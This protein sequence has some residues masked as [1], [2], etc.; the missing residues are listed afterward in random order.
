MNKTVFLDAK[1][2]GPGIDFSEL[3]S[4]GDFVK[5]ED[6]APEEVVERLQ[7]AQTVIVNKTRITAEVIAAC[8]NLKLICVAATGMNN[9]DLDSAAAAGIPVKNAVGYSTGSV[10]QQTFAML[11]A[12]TNRIAFFDNYVKSGQ[13]SQSQLFTCYD[14]VFSELAGKRAG[15]IGLGEI[16]RKSA[17]VLTAMGAEVVYFST[18][19]KNLDQ[20][21]L[22][23]D[24]ND[25]LASSDFLLIHAPLNKD[26]YNLIDAE[27]LKLMKR[28][29]IL[30]N[31]G[32]GK[33][34]NE[35]ALADAINNEII[36]GAA[37]DVFAAEPTPADNPLL[38]VKYPERL[39][40]TPHV[41]WTSIEARNR[42]VKQI[43]ENI[44]GTV[45]Q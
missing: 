5:Y 17:S 19:G 25:L 23:L 14:R 9:I 16:G 27:Q 1:T 28:S 6:T 35:A 36:A 10:V 24:L 31:T 39:I 13:Y 18:S 44:K 12:L 3:E 11:L 29:A 4:L 15:I 34:V 32:R 33:I 2:L 7:D 21:Y 26:T 30:V 45:I 37:F 43:V 42:L 41:A 40:L 38:S 20:P 22:R 8:P